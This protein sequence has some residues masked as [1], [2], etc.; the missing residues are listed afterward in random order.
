V[1][2]E[3]FIGVSQGCKLRVWKFFKRT[4]RKSLYGS[5]FLYHFH[6]VYPLRTDVLVPK[7]NQSPHSLQGA[8]SRK[9]HSTTS[10]A[11]TLSLLYRN[12]HPLTFSP[13][14]STPSPSSPHPTS[15]T[16]SHPHTPHPHPLSD[17]TPNPTT[18][19]CSN[20]YVQPESLPVATP[21]RARRNRRGRGS[22]TA[23]GGKG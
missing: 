22:K 8:I 10:S 3:R 1:S 12:S 9:T 6:D 14:P 18:I 20:I 21:S 13:P 23:S 2:G 19:N 11:P 17:P 4:S 15:P 5:S 16:P 7:P